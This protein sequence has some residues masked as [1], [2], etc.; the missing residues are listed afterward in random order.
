M[1]K[2]GMS[3]WKVT[4]EL[5]VLIILN[6]ESVYLIVKCR[7]ICL[8]DFRV[9][10]VDGGGVVVH[11]GR[12]RQDKDAAETTRDTKNPKEEAVQDHGHNAPVLILLKI[13]LHEPLKCKHPIQ[14]L[15]HHPELETP[16]LW[17]HCLLPRQT[18]LVSSCGAW[19]KWCCGSL[20]RW[21]KARGWRRP[22][23]RFE[24]YSW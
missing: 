24:Q 6:R 16:G 20:S 11:V 23:C 5:C 7:G 14:Q 13:A 12:A 2:L 19:W 3:C 17:S 15:S 9:K 4:I 18:R 21:R 1:F 8:S 22:C 10:N